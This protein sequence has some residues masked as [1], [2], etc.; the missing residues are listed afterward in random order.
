MK[1]GAILADRPGCQSVP[2]RT[3]VFCIPEAGPWAL[4][5]SAD[6]VASTSRRAQTTKKSFAASAGLRLSTANRI[7]S[8]APVP[9]G[10]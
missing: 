3:E 6:S 7:A 10:S 5:P 4:S 2:P 1:K 9:S 8:A